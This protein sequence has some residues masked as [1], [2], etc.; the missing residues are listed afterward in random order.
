MKFLLGLW[1][2]FIAITLW[3]TRANAQAYYG[4]YYD[5]RS[6][7]IYP[8][9]VYAGDV[10]CDRQVR[11]LRSEP[12]LHY[13][14]RRDRFCNP[15][16]EYLYYDGRPICRNNLVVVTPCPHHHPPQPPPQARVEIDVRVHVTVKQERPRLEPE[17]RPHT[18]KDGYHY[19]SRALKEKPRK[20]PEMKVPAVDPPKKLET[21]PAPEPPKSDRPGYCND[22][23]NS[24]RLPTLEEIRANQA[25]SYQ[26][27]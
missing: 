2:A 27:R 22:R 4:V 20:E 10:C 21:H 6:N 9:Y 26:V 13:P 18:H 12:R 15:S 23:P 8:D 25:M 5:V 16:R 19:P 11:Y 17:T 3:P 7:T 14:T 24:H 1:I